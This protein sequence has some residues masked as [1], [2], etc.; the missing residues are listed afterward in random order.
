MTNTKQRPRGPRRLGRAPAR[1]G[2]RDCSSPSSRTTATRSAIE[3]SPEVYADARL[4]GG[5]D[6]IVQCM[7]MGTIEKEQLAGPARRR[8]ST[9]PAWPAGTAASPT[10]TATPSD[11]LHLI[12]GQFAC[13]PGKPP[14]RAHRA[15]RRT[16]T[17]PTASNIVP[18]AADHP[19]TARHRDFDLVTEQYWVLADDYIDVLATTT[20]PKH[21]PGIRGTARSRHPAIW[22]RQWGQGRVFVCD[23]RAPRGSPGAPERAHHHREGHAVGQPVSASTAIT[24][25][26]VGCGAISAQYLARL[27]P[28]CRTSGSRPSPT[29]TW[30]RA[31]G[32][33]DVLT[34]ACAPLTR[35]RAAGRPRRRASSST[36]PSLPAHAEIALPAIAAGKAVYGEKPLAATVAEGPGDSGRRRGGRRCAWAAHRTRCSGTGIQTARKAI[37]D[38]LIGTPI[39]RH[40]HH[41]HRRDTSAGTPTL[42]STTSPAAARCWTWAP[43]TSPRWSPCW[44]RWPP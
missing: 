20:Q 10:R 2:H 18:E 28:A 40:R 25:G 1:R 26:I 12:G 36:S 31:P 24:V 30:T 29:S 15:N 11:Y 38:G 27:S 6:L 42:T 3:E 44:D 5:A 33:A 8:R 23:P 22:T 35:G 34:M 7:T 21:G 4:H 37:D 19:I 32:V 9:A 41:G 39:A 17:S 13:H 16:T 43:T 14:G